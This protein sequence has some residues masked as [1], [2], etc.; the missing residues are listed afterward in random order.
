MH[1]QAVQAL[2]ALDS[3]LAFLSTSIAAG[4]VPLPSDGA[5]NTTYTAIVGTPTWRALAQASLTST[6]SAVSTMGNTSAMDSVTQEAARVASAAL[7][8]ASVSGGVSAI[9]TSLCAAAPR[10]TVQAL[11]KDLSMLVATMYD[12]PDANDTDNL[13]LGASSEADGTSTVDR[14]TVTLAELVT[15][16]QALVAA[17]SVVSTTMATQ[18]GDDVLG[19]LA[20]AA[21]DFGTLLAQMVA[22]GYLQRASDVGGLLVTLATAQS[23]DDIAARFP[24][25]VNASKWGVPAVYNA[26]QVCAGVFPLHKVVYR[27]EQRTHRS[28]LTAKF[29]VTNPPRPRPHAVYTRVL[30]TAPLPR[31]PSPLPAGAAVHL[32]RGRGGL[33][34]RRGRHCH[35]HGGGRRV[36]APD[37]L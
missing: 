10:A 4:E 11:V 29:S 34:R 22:Q 2:A 28:N 17:Q 12:A 19:P 24:I 27:C 32:R 16:H 25:T 1:A 5:S 6:Q 37:P 33:R 14:A 3:T 30:F 8:A 26:T 31:P 15:W 18:L 7:N 21:A 36:A 23:L 35:R 13:M 20:T 9:S